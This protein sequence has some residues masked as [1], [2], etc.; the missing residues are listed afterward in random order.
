M[1][2]TDQE[3]VKRVNA[4]D[5]AAFEAIFRAQYTSLCNF[6]LSYV[7]SHDEAEDL[8]STVF[9]RVWANRVRWEAPAGVRAYLFT[10]VRN[11]ALNVIRGHAHGDFIPIDSSTIVDDADLS[12]AVEQA[13]EVGRIWSAARRLPDMQ[14]LIIS[15]KHRYELS[16]EEITNVTGLGHAAA[17]KQYQ[18][19]VVRLREL[20]GVATT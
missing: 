10:A 7:Q 13:G 2:T 8:V 1:S 6:A 17:V 12:K 4:G 19:G 9:A 5:R 14:R 15:L 18:R 20:L 16:W 3:L 11:G